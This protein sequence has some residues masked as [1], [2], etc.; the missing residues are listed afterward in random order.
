MRFTPNSR[1][2]RTTTMS[3]STNTVRRSSI[4]LTESGMASSKLNPNELDLR[5]FSKLLI[6]FSRPIA[7]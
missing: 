2:R 3:H 4:K 7:F 6:S 1:R 5:T